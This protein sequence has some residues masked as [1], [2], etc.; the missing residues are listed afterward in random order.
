MGLQENIAV[1]MRAIMERQQKSLTEF[2]EELGI[3]RNALYDYIRCK[4]NPSIATVEHIA[5]KLEVDPAA[6]MG[7][8]ELDRQEAAFWLLDTIKEISTAYEAADACHF[9][10]W[11]EET[12]HFDRLL[13]NLPQRAWIE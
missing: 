9:Y 8:F 13:S 7:L 6:L 1:N 10:H 4:G 5:E 3:S 11:Y 12:K 2:S